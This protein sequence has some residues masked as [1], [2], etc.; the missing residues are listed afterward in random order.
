MRRALGL[1]TLLCSIACGGVAAPPPDVP[2]LAAWHACDAEH[3]PGP[4]TPAVERSHGRA[5]AGKMTEE[6]AQ[7]KRLFDGERWQDGALLLRRVADGL[8]DDDLGNRAIARFY[9]AIAEYQA[10]NKI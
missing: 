3:E 9:E 1:M 2:A 10:D 7:A 8:T 4:A 5:T 6:A